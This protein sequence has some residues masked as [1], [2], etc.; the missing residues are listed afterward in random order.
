MLRF[1]QKM[2]IAFLLFILLPIIILGFVSYKISST[3]LQQKISNQTVQT[4]RAVN[5]NIVASVSEVNAFSDYVISSGEIHSFLRT[6]DRTSIIEFYNKKQAIAGIMHGNSQI[7]DF[8]LYSKSGSA[9]HLKNTQ[10]PSFKTFQASLFNHQILQEKGRSVWLTPSE[11]HPFN[12]E[13]RF[14]LTQGRVVKDIDTLTDLGYLILD[15]KLDLFDNIF[16]D[17]QEDTA[18]GMLVNQNGTILYSLDRDLIGKQFDIDQFSEIQSQENGYLIDYWNREKSLITYMPSSFTT[19]TNSSAILISIKPWKDISNDIQHIRNTTLLIVAFAVIIAV[20]FNVLFLKNISRF[21]QELLK[22]M[23]L[24]EVGMLSSRMES[25]K[26]KELEK[27]SLGFNNMISRIQQLLKEV[28]TEQERKREAQF[29]VLQQQINPHFLYNTLESIN[30]LAALNG[31]KEISKM[32]I[33]LGKL[34]RISI[35][36]GY[37]VKVQDEIRHVISYLEIQ[38]IR[39]DNRFSFM[40][41][42]DE[43]LKNEPVLKLILQPLVENILIHAFD[44][45]HVGIIKIRAAM[46]NGQGQFWV[47]DNGKG[48]DKKALLKLNG[49]EPEKCNG[50]GHGIRN[51]QERLGLYY[52]ENY[53]LIICSDEKNGTI[54]KISFPIKGEKHGL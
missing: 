33:N 24:A 13:K 48:I 11:I 38:K 18:Y 50:R 43:G 19:G 22:H 40:V 39:Y 23:K 51:V 2:I 47:E 7:D 37:E 54:I 12:H 35:N 16:K 8:I 27:I 32:T 17:V 53:G 25:F 15:V 4:L 9:T 45:E 14:V 36:G 49:W 34:L 46:T 28:E 3:T 6:N 10:I 52:G 42:V 5:R 29:K 41:E 26:L 1:Q 20:L 31:Q 30:A 21:I 44:Q